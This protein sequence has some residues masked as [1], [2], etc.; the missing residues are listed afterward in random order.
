MSGAVE[1]AAISP[2]A[3]LVYALE[4]HRLHR[5]GFANAVAFDDIFWPASSARRLP[6]PPPRGRHFRREAAMAAARH[7]FIRCL[8]PPAVTEAVLRIEIS[9]LLSASAHA[10]IA[11]RSRGEMRDAPRGFAF[12]LTIVSSSVADS[13]LLT[14][15]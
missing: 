3:L 11:A 13:P 5:A 14:S 6:S 12:S 4:A 10:C 7:A 15:R 2:A 9:A 1:A 8:S